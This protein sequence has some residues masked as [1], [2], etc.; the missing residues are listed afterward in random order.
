MKIQLNKSDGLNRQRLAAH[1]AALPN[2][3]AYTVEIKER[4]EKRTLSQNDLF[5]MWMRELVEHT[6]LDEASLGRP[7]VDVLHDLVCEQF[8]QP[9]TIKVGRQYYRTIRGTRML[10]V[11]Q[12]TELL[13]EIEAWAYGNGWKLTI[14]EEM[15]DQFRA[16]G[17]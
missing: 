17:A 16:E 14:P 1:V 6:K 9:I 11:E 15:S 7:A 12:M 5:W 2:D 10:T 3:R 4:R 8:L 13:N